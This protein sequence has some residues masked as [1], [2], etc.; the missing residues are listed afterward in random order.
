MS[1]PSERGVSYPVTHFS[2][3]P[4]CNMAIS[5]FM[6]DAIEIEVVTA[7]LDAVSQCC[8]WEHEDECL[9]ELKEKCYEQLMSHRNSSTVS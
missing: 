3:G 1:K 8:D 6:E 4:N 7:I 2:K 5:P 9:P